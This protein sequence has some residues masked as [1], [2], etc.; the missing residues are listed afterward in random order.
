MSEQPQEHLESFSKTLTLPISAKALFDWHKRKGAFERLTPP[1]DPVEIIRKDEGIDDGKEVELRVSIAGIPQTLK[2]THQNYQEGVQ[3]EDRQ[4]TGPFAHWVHTHKVQAIT[5]Q[6]S[7][8]TDEIK[9]R[10]PL[11]ALGKI[12]G[13]G[14][15]E[16][17]L[18][19]LFDYRHQIMQHDIKWLKWAQDQK[20]SPKKVIISGA[21]GLV[22]KNLSAFLST[23]GHEVWH[24]TRSAK[25]AQSPFRLLWQE[26]HDPLPT[27]SSFDWVIHLAGE[28]IGQRWNDAIKKK[29][30][31][32]RLSRTKA[33]AQKLAQE[34]TANQVFFSAS[35]IG[36]YGLN[37][38][39]VD[40]NA[41]KGDGFLADLCGDWEE[42]A[43]LAQDQ[44]RSI[45]GR[46]GLVMSLQGG[47]LDRL[48]LPFSLG[49]GGN[50]GLGQRWMSWID[51]NDLIAGIY[52]SLINQSVSGPVNLVTQAV[53]NEMFTKTL[54]KVLSRPTIA[55]IPPFAL[56]TM[57]GEMAN[58]TILASQS[59][60]P[61]K[62]KDLGFESSFQT[63]ADSLKLQ[64]GR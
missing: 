16:S 39:N 44:V 13:K 11:G 34:Q 31:E 3:F 28:N 63:L 27:L 37:A 14:I 18:K 23:Q 36:Y 41:P 20:I 33:L 53:S 4:L 1:W 21:S 54:G 64:L 25:E 46:I 45:Q 40:E 43:K 29:I 32:S 56:Q 51:L 15:A 58:E 52:F 12:F 61:K 57:F 10:L 30:V 42:M 49:L 22:G 38:E 60:I 35:A 5:D 2:V 19:H 62:L 7:L 55:A 26:A 6:S 17:R 50:I 9:Y 59:V 47:A 48:H 8:L 24:F